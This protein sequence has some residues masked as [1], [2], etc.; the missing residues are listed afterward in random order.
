MVECM[1]G[2]QGNT[3]GE[4]SR[5]EALDTLYEQVGLDACAGE[6]LDTTVCLW[7]AEDLDTTI[8]TDDH[9][10]AECV[11]ALNRMARL[12][13]MD[14]SPLVDGLLTNGQAHMIALGIC[15]PLDD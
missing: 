2:E 11:D 15:P 5:A 1:K 9:W 7:T 12:Y 4:M 10:F 14:E 8:C 3:G 13:T 6:L